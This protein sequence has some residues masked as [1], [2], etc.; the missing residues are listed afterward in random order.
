MWVQ[1]ASCEE[2][3]KE[4]W[5]DTRGSGS[6]VTTCI[7][8]CADF[9]TSW[10]RQHF[11]NIQ[12][13]LQIAHA[14]LCKLQNGKYEQVWVSRK[15]EVER[16]I[17]N[18]LEVEETMWQQR[19]RVTWLNKD[20]RNTKFF[21][22]K[23]KS[24]GRNN[25][26]RRLFDDSNVW[27][28]ASDN[29]GSMFCNY[30]NGLFTQTGG[31]DMELVMAAITPCVTMNMNE[32][33]LRPFNRSEL[34]QALGQ[35]YPTKAPGID[36]MP[37]LF[38]Q[39]YWH[40]V[41]DSVS[42]A[43]LRILNGEGSVRDFNHTLI[44]LIPKI[45]QPTRVTD[46]RPISLCTVLYKMI[47]KSFA[48]RLKMVLS[49]VISESQSAFVP[50]RHIIDNVMSAFEV[51][52]HMKGPRSGSGVKMALKL[53]MAKGYDIVDWC[54]VEAMM[55]RLGFAESWRD[56]QGSFNELNNWVISEA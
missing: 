26:I 22:E 32:I 25:T 41:G 49:E 24:R 50:G 19:S 53:D 11:G 21:H 10:N 17:N 37:A 5:E 51:V 12:K 45:A 3:I 43:C 35:M 15:R 44:A 55:Q 29:I 1:E 31:Q 4:A 13:N 38:Y 27:Q 34:K 16:K 20:N 40:I 18:L 2:V 30:F 36:G 52:H 7:A 54:F 6:N 33:L 56:L 14:K 8:H 28:L 46:F 39:R 42:D 9:L 23:A 48:N 47:T